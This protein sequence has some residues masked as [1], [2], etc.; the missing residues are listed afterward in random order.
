MILQRWAAVAGRVAA[1]VALSAT[2]LVTLPTGALA[3]PAAA[4]PTPIFPAVP[5]DDASLTMARRLS[6]PTLGAMSLAARVRTALLQ[7]SREHPEVQAAQAAADTSGFQVESAQR[8]RYPRLKVGTSTG[9]YDSGQGNAGSQSYQLI[10]GELRTSLIDGG[11]ISAR[12]KAAERTTDANNEAVKS[13][14][15][16][17]VLDALTA[18]LQVQRFDLKRQIAH[19]STEVLD[20]LTRAEQRR[21]ALGASGQ[22]DLQTASSRRAGIA[23][24]ESDFDAQR[25]EAAAKFQTYFRFA[26]NVERLP[27]LAVPLQW[28]VRTQ[29]EALRVAE[30]R[31]TELAEARSRVESAKAVVDQQE[32]SIFPTVDAVLVKTKDPR[33]VS[34]QEPTRAALELNWAFGNGFDQSLRVKTALAEVANQEAKMES[35]RLNLD[36]LTSSSWS[37][38]VAGRERERQLRIAVS[39][40]GQAFRGRRRLLEFGRETLPAVLDAQVEYYTLLLDYVDAVFDLRVNEF[41]LARTTG[42][43]FVA[44]DSDNTWINSLFFSGASSPVLSQEGLLMLPCNA[45]SAGCR[46]DAAGR[47]G[48]PDEALVRLRL[49]PRISGI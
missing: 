2:V 43:L 44:P 28:D 13:V 40:A 15:Q 45:G 35:A 25:G 36:E 47:A 41:R 38:T 26:P 42:R 22:N 34:P 7:V 37:R 49:V 12:L 6:P 14:S 48:E 8:A 16:K 27:V 39:E 32:A 17:V 3:Q 24:R 20:E 11:A 46:D 5:G 4:P 1:P 9:T 21:V 23:A 19:R 30:E 10:T 31:S 33:G 29:D 18:Y